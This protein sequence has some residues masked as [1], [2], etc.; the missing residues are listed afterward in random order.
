MTPSIGAA[1]TSGL[2]IARQ[3]A[4]Y[5]RHSKMPTALDTSTRS[6]A[7]PLGPGLFRCFGENSNRYFR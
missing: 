3:R 6:A 2:N 1:P 7:G 4:R 5:N